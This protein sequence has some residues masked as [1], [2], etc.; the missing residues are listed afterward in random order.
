MFDYAKYLLSTLLIALNVYGFWLGGPWVGLG[1]ALLLLV[2]AI[3][4]LLPLNL[5]LPDQRYPWLYDAIVSL[6]VLFAFAELLVF[7]YL[8][9]QNHFETTG[10]FAIAFTSMLFFGFVVG[11]PPVHE[12]FHRNTTGMRTLGRLGLCLV[13]D[14]WREITHVVTHH[15]KVCTFDDPDTARRGENVYAYF[16]RN[17]SGQVKDAIM[18]EREMWTKRGR[19]WWHPANHWVI[20]ALGMIAFFALLYTVGGGSGAV[21]TVL[22]LLFGPRLLLEV[23]NYCNHYGLVTEHP[24]RFARRHTWNHLSPFVRVL[25][26][27]ITNHAG[28]HEDPYRPFYRLQPDAQGPQQPQFL[29]CVM[30]ALVPPIWL[31]VIKPRL[32]DWD[33]RFAT[34]RERE[35]AR[36][37]NRRAGWEDW[38]SQLP[39][40]APAP[41]A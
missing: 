18:L 6:T 2:M 35:L 10:Q 36:E 31:A 32:R 34:P 4:M 15:Q 28:H 33:E 1:L 39:E 37:A 27:E 41:H 14:P 8:V 11:A 20:S 7:A 5:A 23:F 40:G 21:W 17:L 38:F 3:D 12:L 29:L 24:G 22:S 25:A 30:A 16:V 9:G 26:L 19:V 13:C